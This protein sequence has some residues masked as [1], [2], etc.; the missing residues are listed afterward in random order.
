MLLFPINITCPKIHLYSYFSK[1]TFVFINKYFI[2][3]IIK[4]S[5]AAGMFH[6]SPRC[7]FQAHSTHPTFVS[8]SS[9]N[10]IN[11]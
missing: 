11:I 4:T 2:I 7:L 8:H 9:Q 6:F 5:K 10:R 1:Y 3:T